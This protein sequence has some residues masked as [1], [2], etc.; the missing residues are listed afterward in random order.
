M[1]EASTAAVQCEGLGFLFGVLLCVVL[2]R[3]LRRPT[4]THD[5]SRL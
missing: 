1:S 3:Q 5:H 2:V 4:P